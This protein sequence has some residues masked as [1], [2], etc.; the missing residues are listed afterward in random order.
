MWVLQLNDM[1]SSKIEILNSVARAKTKEELEAFIERESV[2][3]YRDER[4]GK[5]FKK[6]GPLEWYN[7]PSLSKNNFV[8]VGDEETWAERA[9][10]D[11]QEMVLA[12]PEI[13]A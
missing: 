2:E 10:V 13:P 11:F 6:D 12:I 1:R 3:T 4:W 5:T 8:D 9:R 7:R